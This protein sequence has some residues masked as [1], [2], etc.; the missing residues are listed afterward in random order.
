MVIFANVTSTTLVLTATSLTTVPSTLL[1]NPMDVT[2]E[3][4]VQMVE[5]ALI[6]IMGTHVTVQEGG[7]QRLVVEEL[8]NHVQVI[9]V[10]TM[11]HAILMVINIPAFVLQVSCI[12]IMFDC[13]P[14]IAT[15]MV[16]IPPTK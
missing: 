7:C 2:M 15:I 14:S 1:T 12:I 5:P 8:M 9:L 10:K 4:A 13:L 16:N 6:T 3:F 11:G